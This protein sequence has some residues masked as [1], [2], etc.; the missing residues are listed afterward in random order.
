MV[1]V[2]NPKT[3]KRIISLILT[4]CLPGA[5]LACVAEN[6]VPLHLEI[7]AAYPQP[8]EGEQEWVEL[9]NTGSATVNLEFYTLEDA[10]ATPFTLSGDLAS[11]ASI[12]ITE[13]PFQL[14][15]GSD[16][17]TL[18]TIHGEVVDEFSYSSSQ[19]GGEVRDEGSADTENSA[20]EPSN[21]PPTL[22]PEYSEALPNPEGTDT[23]EEWIELYNP[24]N[25]TIELTGLS[26]DDQEGGSKAFS[27]SASMAAHEYLLIS[28]EDSGLSL[29][30]TAD[31]IR[32]LRGEE[33]L[34]AVPYTEVQ[35]GKSYAYV[36][37]AYEWTTPTP[38][39]A[40]H[41]T[42]GTG[43][44]SDDIELT[45][46]NPNP[47]GPDNDEEWIEITNGGDQSVD[48]GNWSLDDGPD[49]SDPYVIPEGTII[50]PGE[51][52]IFNRA[53]TDLALNN[54]KDAARLADYSG[55]LMDEIDY[56]STQE[57][58]SYS[59]IEVEEI[60]N[61]QAGTESMGFRTKTIWEWT[62][63]TPGEINPRWKELVGTVQSFDAG[64]LTLVYAS[65]EL[66]FEVS[67]SSFGDLIF[68]P[69]NTLLVQASVGNG[70][71]KLIRAELVE[72]VVQENKTFP[73]SWI[74]LALVAG[75]VLGFET[76]KWHKKKSPLLP[77][78]QPQVHA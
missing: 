4:L 8:L 49:G 1:S 27:L 5:A 61:L 18:K 22:W 56:D 57:G 68:Q 32:L 7:T 17:L 29:N 14:N 31:E 66:L 55:E 26:L 52:L 62:E 11:T 65:S 46:I 13:L 34:W 78:S 71:Y 23:T 20:N 75:A 74:A 10:T 2:P 33:V 16:S 41:A 47:E 35:E 12:Q 25:E 60:Q 24:Y 63:P 38:G 45:E 30:N 77:Y 59:K 76:V 72:Q 58:Q 48:L 44:A 39:E 3:M 69:G 28:V 43:Q 36:N 9:K 15:N 53:T 51:S 21:N 50:E 70:I 37:G 73:W 54:S 64:L 40:N 67:D 6:E 19:A 42:S